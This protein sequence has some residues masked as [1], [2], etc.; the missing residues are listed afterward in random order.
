MI[1]A[2]TCLSNI[3]AFAW[4]AS[5]SGAFLVTWTLMLV[6][7]P[8][9]GEAVSSPMQGNE[10]RWFKGNLHT[11]SLW[12]DG[13]DYPEMIA[14]WYQRNGYQF[15]GISDH[16]VLQEG[17]RW[18]DLK[19]PKEGTGATPQHGGG[20]VLEK[21]LARFG[22]DWV[23]QRES[24]GKTSIRLKPLAE[25]RYRFEGEPNPDAIRLGV[26]LT[27]LAERRTTGDRFERQIARRDGGFPGDGDVRSARLSPHFPA[28]RDHGADFIDD[29]GSALGRDLSG[30][31]H[32]EEQGQQ[33]LG[34]GFH[35]A[36][37]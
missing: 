23:E 4:S 35:L 24:N 1:P 30:E 31:C 3:R 8:C 18:L 16:N 32:T 17:Q 27:A 21:Y 6:P 28:S 26:A 14:D 2:I 7:S 15:L 36:V 10:A 5:L 34:I 25:Y 20:V 11:H 37:V 9:R 19:P 33:M 22:P 13:D 12:S 29:I